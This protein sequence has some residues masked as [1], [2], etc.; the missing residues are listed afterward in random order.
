[1]TSSTY[2]S[3][4]ILEDMG[5]H[6]NPANKI[7]KEE[8]IRLAEH[9]L[10]AAAAAR[11]HAAHDVNFLLLR[12]I[13]DVDLEHEAIQLGFR[14]SVGSLLLKGVLRCKNEEG[15]VQGVIVT[16]GRHDFFLHG[17]KERCLSLW[18]GPVDFICQNHIRE[19]RPLQ[20]AE[21]PPSRLLIHFEDGRWAG[22][23]GELGVFVCVTV[24]FLAG[25]LL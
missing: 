1:M 23:F 16:S 24:F 22:S 14:K 3:R 5:S 15:G 11:S 4:N 13:A 21:A 20:K 10:R 19:D 9:F 6:G 18:R 2:K 17:L 7:L 8:N 12:W 25:A